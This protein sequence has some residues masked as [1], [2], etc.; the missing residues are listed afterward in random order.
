MT[1]EELK[2]KY[3]NELKVLSPR[4]VNT[5]KYFN[6]FDFESFYNYYIIRKNHIDFL[7]RTNC[8]FK[9]KEEIEKFIRIMTISEGI[10]DNL[11]LE[12]ETRVI[13]LNTRAKNILEDLGLLTFELFFD[14]YFIQ[15]KT[16]NF[17]LVRNCGEKTKKELDQFVSNL[18]EIQKTEFQNFGPPILRPQLLEKNPVIPLKVDFKTNLLFEEE[19]NKL[20]IRSKNILIGIG[21]NT[22]NGFHDNILYKPADFILNIRNCGLTTVEEISTFK[23]IFVKILEQQTT[24]IDNNYFSNL[25]YYLST[26]V[27]LRPIETELFNSYYGFRQ[28]EIRVTL[29]ELGYR[30]HLTRERVRQ[31]SKSI[32]RRLKGIIIIATKKYNLNF[33]QYFQDE[34]FVVDQEFVDKINRNENTNF[35][36]KFVSFVLSIT[37][38]AEYSYYFFN[39]K[40]PDS[41]FFIHKNIPIDFI[42]LFHYLEMINIP[43]SN[44][45]EKVSIDDIIRKIPKRE[46]PIG[47]LKT[48]SKEGIIKIIQLFI[49]HNINRKVLIE[50]DEDYLVIKNKNKNLM[51][52]EIIYQILYEYK[53]PMHYSDIYVECMKKRLKPTTESSVHGTLTRR[54]D[55]FGV[56]GPGMY[57][58]REWGGFFGSIGDVAEQILEQRNEPILKQELDNILSRE[59]YISKDSILTVLLDYDLEK[60]FVKIKD[61]KISLRK[62]TKN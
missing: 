18:C 51:M 62:W 52:H 16:I 9:T 31:I 6:V 30:H 13:K 19:F 21:G 49:K 46:Y 61:N 27:F 39:K 47:S 26:S 60:R 24:N 55:I 58:L 45:R 42:R 34:Y 48:F 15:L 3:L 22:I 28:N 12:F 25:Y 11:K 10:N 53:R 50:I 57:G 20:S 35:S 37:C 8:G 40:S 59:L 33:Y 29:T 44:S 17:K 2:H 14:L 38:P 5:L 56:K 1:K 43:K 41:V 32:Q 54:T 23:K 4:A 36:T 7:K